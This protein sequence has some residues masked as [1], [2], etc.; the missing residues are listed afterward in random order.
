MIQ[1]L[2]SW[3]VGWVAAMGAGG[4][5]WVTGGSLGV[6]DI[7]SGVVVGVVDTARTS[8]AAPA[9]IPEQWALIV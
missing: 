7:G 4:C 6:G 1:R 5:G 2:A 9:K 3:L 8:R